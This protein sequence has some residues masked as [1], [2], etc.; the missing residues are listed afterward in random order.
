MQYMK[1]KIRAYIKII[2]PINCIM[3]G[4]GVITGEIIVAKFNLP[5]LETILAFLSGFFLTAAAMVLNDYIDLPADKVNAP[6]RPI[7]SGLIS[8]K[9][10]LLYYVLLGVF[11]VIFAYFLTFLNFII[12]IIYFI[13]ASL[14]DIAIKRTGLIGNLIVSASVAIPFVF[15][16]VLISNN[17]PTVIVLFFLV[18]FLANTGREIIKGIADVEGD[19][20][21]GYKTIAVRLGRKNAAI[22]GSLFIYAA[23]ALSPLPFIWGYANLL[24]LIIVSISD[25]VF[26]KATLIILK[27]SSKESAL[28]S[29]KVILLA[30]FIA[31]ISFVSIPFSINY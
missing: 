10:A 25:I 3:I 29:K 4:I 15:G 23:I 20:M 1:N 18:A 12:A 28:K 21:R 6:D 9:E 30:M 31:L 16:A 13:L 11:G 7:P 24:Y 14:Y 19:K 17:L 5:L 8:P 27:N 26:I 2:R 22:L